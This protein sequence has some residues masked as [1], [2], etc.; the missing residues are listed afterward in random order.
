MLSCVHYTLATR[1]GEA[2]AS[3]TSTAAPMPV[4]AFSRLD[5]FNARSNEWPQGEKRLVCYFEASGITNDTGVKSIF[6][7]ERKSGRRA[8]QTISSRY[9]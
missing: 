2:T 4:A 5:V 3:G 6:E 1:M 7:T 9:Y 8:V